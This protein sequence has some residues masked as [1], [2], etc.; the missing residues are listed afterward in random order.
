MDQEIFEYVDYILE[1]GS[2]IDKSY[3]VEAA[4]VFV[5]MEEFNERV[6]YKELAPEDAAKQFREQAEALISK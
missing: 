1:N 3:P 4:E 2:P 6:L 5:L